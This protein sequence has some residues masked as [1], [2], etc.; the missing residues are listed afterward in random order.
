MLVLIFNSGFPETQLHLSDTMVLTEQWLAGYG[1]AV[2]DTTANW[3]DAILSQLA[4]QFN[5][6]GAR[7]VRVDQKIQAVAVLAEP[8]IRA[9]VAV[10]QRNPVVVTTEVS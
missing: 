6:T 4:V 1:N 5:A 3:N 2:N 10:V 7:A 8:S 9:R